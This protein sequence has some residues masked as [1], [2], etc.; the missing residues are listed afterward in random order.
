MKPASVAFSALACLSVPVFTRN[1]IEPMG[2]VIAGG[3][4]AAA[5]SLRFAALLG[6]H[7][8]GMF[9][10]YVDREGFVYAAGTTR[11][12]SFPGSRHAHQRVIRGSA[13]A[14]VLKLLPEGRLVFSTLVGG[15]KREHHIGL[16]V[17]E[18]ALL[19][20]PWRQCRED[21]R[22]CGVRGGSKRRIAGGWTVH[23][24]E[25]AS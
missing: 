25:E 15:T 2:M 3:D 20:V 24:L 21:T 12:R 1:P 22:G 18:S 9:S 19:H 23:C 6:Q 14:F 8:G 7:A 5:C 4:G 17:D 10:A 11:D 16:T 13:G